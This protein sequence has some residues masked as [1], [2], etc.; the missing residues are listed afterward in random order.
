MKK[1]NII[2]EDKYLLIINK[3]AKLLTIATNKGN[4]INLYNEVYDY[5]HKK[6]QK[7]FIVNRLDKDTSGLVM[8]AK[9]EEI[10]NI[11]QNNWKDV[12]RKYY[13]IVEGQILKEGFIESYLKET[14]TLLTYST[15]DK[16]GKY[17]K[18]IYKPIISNKKYSLIEINILTGR[19]NQIRVHMQDI[20]H[21]I[22]GDKKY[23]SI[24]NPI[25]RMCL[26]AYYLKFVHPKTKELI[27]LTTDLP[28]EFNKFG[29]NIK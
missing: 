25:N 21:P 19:K 11:M 10:K 2:Y 7:V 12:I 3:P 9:S 23:G 17:A 28:K 4:E 18:T 5:L 15:K 14:K 16:S 1:L 22:V 13:A 8:F 24:I 27:E 29:L 20:K 26:H 6:N